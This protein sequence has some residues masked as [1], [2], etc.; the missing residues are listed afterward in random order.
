VV[1]GVEPDAL[2]LLRDR[3]VPAYLSAATETVLDTGPDVVG[4][5]CTFNQVLPSLALA[6]RLKAARPDLTILLGGACVH[7]SMGTAYRSA[8]P[9]IVDY[10]FTGEADTSFPDW[11]QAFAD[12]DPNRPIPGV[13]GPHGDR[14]AAMTHDLDRLPVPDFCGYFD[15]RALLEG[16]GHALASV[17]HLP[18][19]SSRGC[20][21]GQ[22]HHC[23]FCG[24][25]N[26]GMLFRRKSP[27]RVV[28]ELEQLASTHGITS[29]MASDNI[30]DFHA[31][32]DLLDRLAASPV[33]YDL[34]Y[35]IKANVRRADIA[36]L[37]RAGVWRVQPGIESFSDHVLALMRK[38]VTAL[39][40]VQLLKWLQEH[41][42]HVDYNVL[43]GFPGETAADYENQ[44]RLLR[45]LS[46]LPPPNGS[47]VTVRVDRFSPFYDEPGHL[48]VVDIRA[49][50]Q[51]RYL[52]PPDV[53]DPD[54]F[55]YFFDRDE[56]EVRRFSGY[57]DE[58]GAIIAAWKH[59]SSHRRARLGTGFI[60]IQSWTD[61]VMHRRV[62]R[63]IESAAFVLADS[64][65]GRTAL[66]ERLSAVDGRVEAT[67]A[68]D[69]LV[70]ED[71][72]LADGDRV[73]AL[74][75]YATP[76]TDEQLH[77]WL[78]REVPMATVGNDAAEH[79]RMLPVVTAGSGVPA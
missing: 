10:V 42:V 63:G 78:A 2:H 68:I 15:R 18:Y 12:G 22:K 79:R 6:H 59:G 52:I 75:P 13:A 56:S 55:A 45:H 70:A 37:R 38:G 40:N 4:F 66:I 5:T 57:I 58:I 62:L 31:Y 17:R 73:L 60:E 19:E 71:V 25:N 77:A 61:G 46:H 7:G 43:V 9:D 26:E 27:A 32:R 11:L 72:L 14:P 74:V 41:G 34:F 28:A 8:F 20:W 65:I 67:A 1:D 21:W 3:D 23:T 50:E 76:H 53:L 29:F 44:I 54:R 48:G 33:E 36:A 24:L 35:E 39:A 64:H 69:R 49:A 51:Y 16:A 30:L 47:A